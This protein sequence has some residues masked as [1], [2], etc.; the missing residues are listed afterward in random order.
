[1]TRPDFGIDEAEQD[2]RR[3]VSRMLLGCSQSGEQVVGWLRSRGHSED[4]A[5]W[6]LHG[7]ILRGAL[8]VEP[9]FPGPGS[10][11]HAM[12][13]GGWGNYLN[14]A[15]R[16]TDRPSDAH[17]PPL[18]G[19]G[20]PERRDASV[21]PPPVAASQHEAPAAIPT[22]ATAPEAQ[23]VATSKHVKL[24]GPGEQPVVKNE[25]KPILTKARYDVVKALLDAGEAGLHKDALAV[26][27]KHS[28]PQ[29]RL[30]ELVKDRDWKSVIQLP[31]TNGQ[32]K[33][34][35]IL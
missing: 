28:E 4:A 11:G 1:M 22:P 25:K 27:S 33:G 12:Y 31:G 29:K 16:P 15:V 34:Y 23:P 21:P 5:H 13:R 2:L 32:G 14:I 3:Y 26:K 17:G 30:Y 10:G 8:I 35:R 9:W 18:T 24:F 19:G 20:Y 6:A 7:L